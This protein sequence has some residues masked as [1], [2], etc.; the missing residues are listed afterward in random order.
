MFD[1]FGTLKLDQT[2]VV[3]GPPDGV[4]EVLDAVV[5]E[6]DQG[7]V[8]RHGSAP[9]LLR[10]ELADAG[11]LSSLDRNDLVKSTAAPPDR[12]GP[13]T[14]TRQPAIKGVPA[15]LEQEASTGS[16]RQWRWGRRGA[17]SQRSLTVNHGIQRAVRT[18][19]CQP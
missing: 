1:P 3:L 10:K 4:A 12:Q 17:A 16:G 2:A 18:A 15:V 8:E 19:A 14:I 6:V 9:F 7:D 5:G 11:I 13:K